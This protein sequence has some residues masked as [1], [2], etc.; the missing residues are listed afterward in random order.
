MNE[1]VNELIFFWFFAG[2]LPSISCP[3][4][5]SAAASSGGI[6]AAVSFDGAVA[7]DPT[8]ILNLLMITYLTSPMVFLSPASPNTSPTISGTFNLGVT[9]VLATAEHDGQTVACFYTV[10]GMY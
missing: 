2:S 1:L 4:E 7:R 9:Y 5:Q 6:T 8:N 3:G 10:R